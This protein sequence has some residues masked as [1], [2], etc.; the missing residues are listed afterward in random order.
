MFITLRIDRTN[1]TKKICKRVGVMSDD[2]Y[3]RAG[4]LIDANQHLQWPRERDRNRDTEIGKG[5]GTA[6]ASRVHSI[7]SYEKKETGPFI[8]R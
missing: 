4:C 2:T 5:S 3:H 8:G 6:T 7:C 1:G